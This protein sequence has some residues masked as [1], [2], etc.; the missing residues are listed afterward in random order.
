MDKYK[1]ELIKF[2]KKYRRLPVYSEMMALFSFASKNSVFKLV[3]KLVGEGFLTKD[4]QGH[5]APAKFYEDIKILGTVEAGFP[6]P[7]EEELVDVMNL[8]DYLITNREATFM[9]K[10]SGE[11]MKEAGIVPGDI[12]LVDRSAQPRAGDIVIAEVDGNWT[13][14]YFRKNG[15]RIYLEPANKK[16]KNI[17]PQNDLKIAAVVK[18]VVRKY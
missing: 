14:K 1:K 11:S 6:S 12:V 16:F 17:I 18:G 15:S 3:T 5:L 2:Y 10:V 9:L 8:E 7:A 13:M 4:R